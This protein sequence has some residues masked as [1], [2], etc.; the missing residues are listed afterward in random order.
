MNGL[1]AFYLKFKSL[2]R[3]NQMDRFLLPLIRSHFYYA[4]PNFNRFLCIQSLRK[5]NRREMR[6]R[7]LMGPESLIIHNLMPSR[8]RAGILA[9]PDFH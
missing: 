5:V 4:S 1:E 2:K 8:F 9:Y 3:K 6:D 7:Y